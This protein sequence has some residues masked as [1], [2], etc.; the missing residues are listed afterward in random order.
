MVHNILQY[1]NNIIVKKI[2]YISI[3]TISISISKKYYNYKNYNYF[4]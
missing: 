4:S 3:A 1:S 2:K